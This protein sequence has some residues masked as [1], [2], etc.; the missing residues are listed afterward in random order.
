MDKNVKIRDIPRISLSVGNI[1]YRPISFKF[2][3]VLGHGKTYFY[4]NLMIQ[5]V[6]VTPMLDKG[7]SRDP[8][9]SP[10]A[11]FDHRTAPHILSFALKLSLKGY[12]G[13]GEFIVASI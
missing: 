7:V 11:S 10:M 3:R 6:C 1:S 2:N 8:F 4:I 9:R 5:E 12:W 13:T